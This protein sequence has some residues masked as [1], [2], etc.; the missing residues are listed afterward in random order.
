MD[1]NH[2]PD[3]IGSLAI[4]PKGDKIFYLVNSIKGSSGYIAKP[5]GLNKKLLFESPLIE[6]TLA[7]PKEETITFT[8]KPSAKIGGYMYFMN[9]STGNFSKVLGNINGLTTKTNAFTTEVLYSDSIK[10]S[11]RLY[12]YN[13][14]KGESKLLPWNTFPEK[15]LWSNTD[16]KIIYCAVPKSFALGDYPDMW[17]QGLTNFTDDIWMLNT[18]TQAATLVYDI[19]QETSQNIIKK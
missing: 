11:P 14:K 15:C 7:W 19:E 4:N 9:S 3:G 6:W 17:Y 5:D 8:T 1:G 13:I 2:L 12:L 10:G 18:D 16:S